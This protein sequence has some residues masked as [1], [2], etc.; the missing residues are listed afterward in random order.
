MKIITKIV[1]GK[2]SSIS[3]NQAGGASA[4]TTEFSEITQNF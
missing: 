2:K 4:P 1:T 3:S